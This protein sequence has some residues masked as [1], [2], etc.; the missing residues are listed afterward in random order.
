MFTVSRSFTFS[1]A[2]HLTR[3]PEGHKCRRP[4]GHN[5]KVILEARAETLDDAAMVVD[6]AELDRCAESLKVTYDHQ[7]LN[8]VMAVETT[9]EMIAFEIYMTVTQAIPQVC[10]VTVHESDRSTATFRR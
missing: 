5:Y 3:V 6:Y 4:H 8:E 1:A 9:A 2:H 7:D 10:A